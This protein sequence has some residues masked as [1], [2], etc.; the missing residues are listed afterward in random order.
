MVKMMMKAGWSFGLRKEK[1]GHNFG[2]DMGHQN[3]EQ[4]DTSWVVVVYWWWCWGVGGGMK[5]LNLKAR[6]GG[7]N[8]NN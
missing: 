7:W 1:K 5:S 2:G 4:K 3:Q 8:G 6:G